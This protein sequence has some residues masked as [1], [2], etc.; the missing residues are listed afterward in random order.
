MDHEHQFLI[1]GGILCKI[2][3]SNTPP[4]GNPRELQTCVPKDLVWGLIEQ[5]HSTRFGGHLSY[6]KVLLKLQQRYFWPDMTTDVR[7]LINQCIPCNRFK[8]GPNRKGELSPI[9]AICPGFMLGVDIIGPMPRTSEN[10]NKYIV[11]FMDYFTKYPWAFP[12]KDQTAKTVLQCYEK[13][14]CQLGVPKLILSDNGPAFI[15]EEYRTGLK[16]LGTRSIYTP[17]LSPTSKWACRT[18]EPDS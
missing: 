4:R 3:R 15:S 12:T 18:L 7:D 13:V 5:N 6:E 14:V 10:G 11:C 8:P 17:P 16:E 2:K 9:K 1:L